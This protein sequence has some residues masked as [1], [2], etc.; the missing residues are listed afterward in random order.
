MQ[1]TE[2]PLPKDWPD[3]AKLAMRHVVSMARFAAAYTRSWCVNSPIERLRLRGEVDRL[4]DELAAQ[5]EVARIVCARFARVDA[6]NRPHYRPTERMAILEVRA[7]R[8][9]T[10]KRTAD[11]FLV[12]ADTVSMWERRLAEEGRDALVRMPSPVNR[13]PDFVRCVVQTLKTVCPSLGSPKIAQFLARGGLH[14]AVNTIRRMQRIWPRGKPNLLTS[15]QETPED[16]SSAQVVTARRPDHTWHVDLTV[17]PTAGGF[18]APW[19]PFAVCQSWPFCWWVAV[20]VDHFSRCVKGFAVFQR[21]P[22]R[23]QVC[24]LLGKLIESS[25]AC[26][27]YIITDHGQQ[28]R[29]GFRKWCK[30]HQ[31][32]IKPRRG[33]VGQ[34]GGLA[35]IERFI[36]SMKDECTRRIVVPFHLGA[37]RTELDFYIAW[38]NEFRPHSSL[39]GATP[40]E[41]YSGV[42]PANQLPRLEPRE[43]WPVDSVC[44]N[45]QAPI[46]GDPGTRFELRVSFLEGRKH[47]PI[48]EFEEAA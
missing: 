39:N 10:L 5:Q 25:G 40:A 15:R 36:R 46:R 18:W 14:L 22:T 34:Y 3:F 26:P 11:A 35:V 23:L 19:I 13:Y 9:W 21:A 41:V 44:A 12:D 38:Y 31:P 20:V 48:V 24:S 33:A 42:T 30:D 16:E 6:R 8:G 43:R 7:A 37:M 17:V 4:R 1:P 47:L 29:E 28:F 27:K 2:I 45:P 32:R